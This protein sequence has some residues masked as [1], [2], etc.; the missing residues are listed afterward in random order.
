MRVS[1]IVLAVALGVACCLI[2]LMF[3]QYAIL[4]A[5]VA[6]AEEQIGIFDE[7]EARAKLQPYE[8]GVDALQYVVRYYPSG[9]KQ[10]EGSKLDSVV[11]CCRTRTAQSIIDILRKKSGKDLGPNPE[12]WIEDIRK[13]NLDPASAPLLPP[14]PPRPPW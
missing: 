11:E 5:R 14:R 9:T 7:M 3:V 12:A 6:L 1:T 2:V 4:T 8:N 10:V 13:E